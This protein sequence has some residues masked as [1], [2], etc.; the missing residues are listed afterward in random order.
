MRD[1]E[2]V[3]VAQI[4]GKWVGG[5]VESVVLNYFQNID[6]NKIQFDFICDS[7]STNIPYELIENLGGKVIIIPPYQKVFKYHKEL[8]KILKEGKYKIVHS[9]I[10]VLSVFSLF[11]AWSAKVPIRI[12]HSHSTTNSKEKKKN[13]FKFFLRPLNKIFATDYMACTEHAGRWMFGNKCFDNG[14]VFVLNNAINLDSYKYDKNTR[15]KLRRE[16]K[17]NN[18]TKVIGCIGRFVDQKNH[19]FLIDVFKKYHEINKDSM[20]LL[21]GQGP[22]LE[23]IKEKVNTLGLNEC[24]MFLGQKSDAN[25]YYSVFDCYVMPSIYEG[26]GMVYIEAQ[27]SGLSCLA[28][29]DVPRI[30]KVTK[31][32]DFMNLSE[33]IDE[34]AKKINKIIYTQRKDCSSEVGLAGYDITIEVQ[35][36]ENKYLD[37]LKG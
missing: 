24:V 7:D 18:S 25:K 8:K 28:S 27:V 37:L 21:L 14:K 33:N 10:N 17:I 1:D 3:R 4:M 29:T 9:H 6:K 36:L 32:M 5:G 34:W 30:A 15:I 31:N 13:L 26:L 23:E 11:A 12:A 16:L 35:K 19:R 20:L 2:P 22:L